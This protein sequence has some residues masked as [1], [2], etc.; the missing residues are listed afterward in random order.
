VQQEEIGMSRREE[1]KA[2][3]KEI[4]V[5]PGVYQIRNTRNGKVFVEATR[6]VK[7]INGVQFQLEMGSH[8][9]KALQQDWNE[10]GPEAFAFDVLEILEKPATGYFDEKD[11]LKK[12]KE[13]WLD[14][15][16]PYGDRGYHLLRDG[17]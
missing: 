4:K 16:Q 12:L 3:A 10:F 11:A 1:L 14:Q 9:N 8:M 17:E 13:K 15:L 5:E 2:M 6:N 7:T